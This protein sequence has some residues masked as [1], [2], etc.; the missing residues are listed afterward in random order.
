M[1]LRGISAPGPPK[2]PCCLEAFCYIN[3]TKKHPKIGGFGLVHGFF[4]KSESTSWLSD[5]GEVQEAA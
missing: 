3:P 1:G 2:V 4:F 5:R